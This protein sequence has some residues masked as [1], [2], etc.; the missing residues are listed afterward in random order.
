MWVEHLT[1]FQ[2]AVTCDNVTKSKAFS[3]KI[4]VLELENTL[5]EYCESGIYPPSVTY[6]RSLLTSMGRYHSSNRA[7]FPP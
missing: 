7:P 2:K 6:S 5:N 4:V 1:R 3:A